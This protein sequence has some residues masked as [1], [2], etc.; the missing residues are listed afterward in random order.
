LHIKHRFSDWLPQA[1]GLELPEADPGDVL[2]AA[3]AIM[4]SA[5]LGSR[6][7]FGNRD[8]TFAIES[9]YP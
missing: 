5:R 4:W 2:L 3:S 6:V 1:S 8:H 9:G 7:T